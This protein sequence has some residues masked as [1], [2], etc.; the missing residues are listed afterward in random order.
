MTLQRS[1]KKLPPFPEESRQEAPAEDEVELVTEDEEG[2]APADDDNTFV[3]DVDEEMPDMAGLIDTPAA[4][5]EERFDAAGVRSLYEH[6]DYPL[7]RTRRPAMANRE[8]RGNREK[9]KPKKETPKQP[10]QASSFGRLPGMGSSKG[11]S[12]GKVGPGC[13]R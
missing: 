2:S 6:A 10:A 8:Q 12:G 4:K 5:S 3:E 9:R 11:S 1:F 13:R 7:E